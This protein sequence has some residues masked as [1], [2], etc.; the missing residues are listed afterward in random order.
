MSRR[1]IVI[2]VVVVVFVAGVALISGGRRARVLAAPTERTTEVVEG[3]L[4]IFVTGTG[5]V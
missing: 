3:P 5:K 1:W 4:Q 2:G